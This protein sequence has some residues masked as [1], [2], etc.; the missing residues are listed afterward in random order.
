MLA[1]S[2]ALEWTSLLCLVYGGGCDSGGG[3]GGG[4]GGDASGSNSSSSSSIW[5]LK[6]YVFLVRDVHRAPVTTANISSIGIHNSN[7]ICIKV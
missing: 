2:Q 1:H 4:G 3:G 6:H 7:G 5:S